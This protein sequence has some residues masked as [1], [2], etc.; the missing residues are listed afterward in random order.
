MKKGFTLVELLGVFAI[1]SLIVLLA[2]P[3]V[4]NLL[5]QTEQ[6]QY[7]NFENNIFLA[8]EA[9]LSSNRDEYLELKVENTTTYVTVKTLL[10]SDY[11]DS[12]LVNPKTSNTLFDMEEYNN[13]VLVK[14]ND[15][16]IWEYE[17]YGDDE[18]ETITSAEL[19]A[20]NAYDSLAKNATTDEVY[21]VVVLARN[22]ATSRI[23]TAL[24][25]R[26]DYR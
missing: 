12:T 19:A 10:S 8:A 16:K 13:V 20:I 1:M 23:K 26:I 5:K 11:L 4:T 3:A 25:N 24:N 15:K 9:Y 17:L 6:E 14:M 2:A 22:L 7:K 18:D 21:N